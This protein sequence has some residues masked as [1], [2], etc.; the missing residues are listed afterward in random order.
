MSWETGNFGKH[1]FL[2]NFF[3]TNLFDR[4]ASATAIDQEYNFS[5]MFLS[6]NPPLGR[7][8]TKVK[9][10]SFSSPVGGVVQELSI[11]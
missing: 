11:N 2:L 6:P 1:S 4:L 7:S 3:P 5:N 9:L 8:L 10:S